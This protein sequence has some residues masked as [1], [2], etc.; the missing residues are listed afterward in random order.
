[1]RMRTWTAEEWTHVR[2]RG[3]TDFMVRYGVL[4]RGLPLGALVA[5]A[6][7]AALGTTFPDAFTS[8]P[9]LLRV[10]L[11]SAVFS[12]SGCIRASYTWTLHEKRF[13]GGA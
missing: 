3:K 7:E 2:T 10:V 5:V 13:S 12:V 8:P 9:F 6:V 1:M 11:F 4:L